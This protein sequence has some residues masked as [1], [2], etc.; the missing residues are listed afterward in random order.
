LLKPFRLSDLHESMLRAVAR[1]REQREGTGLDGALALQ[2]LADR[3]EGSQDWR[4]LFDGVVAMTRESTLAEVCALM[5][6]EEEAGE[7][8][9]VAADALLPEA[10]SVLAR[11]NPDALHRRVD[12]EGAFATNEAETLY[13]GEG[14]S[15]GG[16]AAAPVRVMRIRGATPIVAMVIVAATGPIA[17]NATAAL[18]IGAAVLG[19]ALTRR[20]LSSRLQEIHGQNLTGLAAL[21]E[22]KDRN[23]RTHTERVSN[24][25]RAVVEH[26]GMDE[27]TVDAVTWG[28]RLHDIGKVGVSLE[29]LY[30]KEQLTDE[31]FGRL[32]DHAWMG[33]R[34]LEK[35]EVD[36]IIRDCIL[37]HHER[38]DGN[39]YPNGLGGEDI[40]LGARVLSVCDAYDAITGRRV[41][42]QNCSHAHAVEELKR[43]AGR[44]FDPAVVDAFLIAVQGFLQDGEPVLDVEI[45]EE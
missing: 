39:G 41:Y 18:E 11:V 38:W 7:W 3:A 14:A 21:I 26:M 9:T 35:V 15:A 23:L 2:Q 31:E 37:F 36:G 28:A 44:Q 16:I 43:G 27:A 13:F 6:Y 25:A 45:P 1:A 42:V 10:M 5:Y 32:K 4:A 30:K 12:E 34:I 19:N 33:Q 40:P 29:L 17:A 8:N 24:Y 22:L 20:F